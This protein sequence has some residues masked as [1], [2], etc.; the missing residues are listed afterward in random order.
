MTDSWKDFRDQFNKTEETEPAV[1]QFK[2]LNHSLAY[3]I[4]VAVD[5]ASNLLGLRWL[6][7]EGSLFVVAPSGHGKSSLCIQ[8]VANWS[9][10]R[11]AFGIKPSRPLRI[12]VVESE[13]D[14]ADNK[15]FVQ[16]IR[17]M[18]LNQS[19]MD[20]LTANTRLEFRR[21][22]AG[23]RFF[24]ALDQFL[25]QYPADIVLIN[26][27]TGFCTIDMKDEI[28]MNDWLRNRLNAVMVKHS[29]APIIVAHMP[30]S[31]VSQINDKDWFEWMYVLSGCVTLTNW[32]RA[33]LV[34]VPMKVRGVYKFIT[35]KRPAQ[36]GWVDPESYFAHSKKSVEVNG[37]DFEVIQW[38]PA[39]DAQIHEAVPEEE[40]KP[41]KN[42][43]TTELIYSKMSPIEDY[44][45]ESWRVW[46]KGTFDIGR[47]IADDFRG[48]MVHNGLISVILGEGHGVA[49]VKFFRKS[50]NS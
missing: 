17:T 28:G 11:I 36:S 8:C 10:G 19:E 35:A 30:K 40:H 9:I 15:A 29:C 43:I 37:E 32:A 42:Q 48:A 12:L 13:D 47:D 3:F 25:E 16:V 39:T 1:E 7:R 34:F 31:Q 4:D 6:T 33:I 44:T 46:C 24:S 27:L 41:K 45:R 50:K 5:P 21:D 18:N 38:L 2:I 20:L 14:D 49:K 26:P 22:L 23:D